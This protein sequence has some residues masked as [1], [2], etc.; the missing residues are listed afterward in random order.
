[1]IRMIYYASNFNRI[2]EKKKY[3]ISP[4]FPTKLLSI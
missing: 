1:M 2:G 4:T 3:N